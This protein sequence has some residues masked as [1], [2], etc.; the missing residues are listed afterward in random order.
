MIEQGNT[1]IVAEKIAK[2]IEIE[3]K[4]VISLK[5]YPKQYQQTI[6]ITEI[7]KKEDKYVPYKDL[8][9]N[10]DEHREIFIGY[11]NWHGTLP[12]IV[13]SFLKDHNFEKKEIFPFCTHEG[14]GL[15]NS[16]NEIKSLCSDANV[17]I[18]LPIRGSKV[19]RGNRAISNWLVQYQSSILKVR[20]K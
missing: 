20:T 9:V 18:G 10:I 4:Q 7:E 2:M 6:K 19:D 8:E 17:Y 14:S 13:T 11:P 15:G 3:M 16:V 12:R 1:E 5:D